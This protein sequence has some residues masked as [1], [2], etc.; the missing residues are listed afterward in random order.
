MNDWIKK[1][2]R[3]LTTEVFYTILYNFNIF[4]NMRVESIIAKGK[5][6]LCVNRKGTEII[7][8]DQCGILVIVREFGFFHWFMPILPIVIDLF[9]HFV[10]WFAV[11]KQAWYVSGVLLNLICN[12]CKHPLLSVT[13]S[14]MPELIVHGWWNAIDA[15]GPGSQKNP[16]YLGCCI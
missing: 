13:K 6:L 1:Y 4:A 5:E 12:C 3:V 8:H 16:D 14:T 11:C 9:C 2:F 15:I 10:V 7:S